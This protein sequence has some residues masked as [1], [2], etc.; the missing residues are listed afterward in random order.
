MGVYDVKMILLIRKDIGMTPG[1]AIAQGSHAVLGVF[2]DM[3][4]VIAACNDGKQNFIGYMTADMREWLEGSFAKVALKCNNSQDIEDAEQWAKDNNIPYKK[5]TD[6]GTTQFD[7]V[8]TITCIAVGP[9]RSEILNSYF[10][11]P[12]P[13]Q[14]RYK[15]Y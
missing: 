14:P 5:I 4:D 11:G 1:K 9:C 12:N 7:N 13:E 6:N 3:I 10:I 8:P 15:L 2:T